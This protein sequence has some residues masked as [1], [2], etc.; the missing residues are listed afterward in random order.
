MRAKGVIESE[1]NS[2][3]APASARSWAQLVAEYVAHLAGCAPR[4]VRGVSVTLGY[5]GSICSPGSSDAISPGLCERYFTARRA[6]LPVGRVPAAATLNREYRELAAL[7]R[8]AARLKYLPA[9][10]LVGVRR[11]A[12]PRRLRRVPSDGDICRLLAAVPAA[13]VDDAQAWHLLIL[14]GWV[15]GLRQAVVVGLPVGAFELGGADLGG[16]GFVR[17][18][19]AKTAKESLHGLPP[20][21]ADRVAARLAALPAGSRR[22]FPW[23]GFRRDIWGRLRSHAAFP[24]TFQ[25][26]RAAAGTRAAEARALAE[27]AAAL[28]H[29]G[30]AVFAAHY[31]DVA[32][33]QAAVARRLVLPDLPALPPYR[34]PVASS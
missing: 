16:V 4:H 9:S 3:V 10:P 15:S 11:P 27:G 31:A 7:F 30:A 19:S 6:G 18:F 1:L 2:W 24:F 14:L 25:S 29:S 20:V 28:D 33:I 12:I 26:L 5:F 17:A 23:P 21:V 34:G 22:F 8:W 13:G 32:R